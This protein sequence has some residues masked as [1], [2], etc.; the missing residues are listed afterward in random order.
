[1]SDPIKLAQKEFDDMKAKIDELNALMKDKSKVLMKEMFAAFFKKYE[2]VVHNIFWTQYT[3]YFN[4]GEACEFSVHEAFLTLSSD[5]EDDDYD[6]D[7]EGSTIYSEK[8]LEREQKNL[9]TMIE[10]EKDP[11]AAAIKHKIDYMTRYN[12]NPFSNQDYYNRGKTEDELMRAWKPVY[13][14]NTSDDVRN[15]ISKIENFLSE[16]KDLDKD[17]N[18]VANMISSI[19]ENLM[20]AM[21]GDHVKVVVTK[22]GIETEEYS[23]D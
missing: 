3:P 15:E 8:D 12:R 21:F 13:S 22:D 19:D 14:Y 11:I 17:F 6:D 9:I 4:D 10:W 5:H 16:N 7:G 1:M 18:V 2:N 20:R 23:H